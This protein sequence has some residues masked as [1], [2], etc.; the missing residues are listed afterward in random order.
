MSWFSGFLTVI[1]VLDCL[2]LILL[3]LIQLPKKEAGMG[4]AFGGAATDALFGAGSG[5]ALTKLTKYAT[6]I[7]F[8]LALGVAFIDARQTDVTKKRFQKS[9]ASEANKL[10]VA[11]P[12]VNPNL[13]NTNLTLTNSS[14]PTTNKPGPA[15]N[16]ENKTPAAPAGPGAAAAGTPPDAKSK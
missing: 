7:F 15:T 6:G 9:V 3:V 12:P 5:N 1:L 10:P 4:T 8:I 16:A 14:L 13:V 11:P 2:L